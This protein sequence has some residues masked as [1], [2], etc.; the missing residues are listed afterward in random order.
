MLPALASCQEPNGSWKVLLKIAFEMKVSVNRLDLEGIFVRLMV[1]GGAGFI[2]SAVVLEGL[3][4]PG[5]SLVNVDNLTYAA[6]RTILD[7]I[8]DRPEHVFERA[9]IRDRGA[10]LAILHRHSPDVIMHLAAETHVDRSIDGPATFIDTNIVGTSVLLEAALEYW[11][12]LDSDKRKA[13]RFL[14]IS[15]DEVFGDLG[16][17]DPAFHEETRYSPSS[18]YSASKAGSDHLVRAWY[19]TYGLPVLITNCSNNYGP[20]QFPEKLIPLMIANALLGKPLPVYGNGTN[21]RDWLHVEDHAKALF[22][23]LTKGR[24]GETY[25]VGGE[26]ECSNIGLVRNICAELEIQ[27][28]TK[29]AG[30]NHYTDL[31]EFITDRP[32]HDHRYAVDISKIRS[33]LDWSPQR[34]LASGIRD[35]VA[36]YLENKDWWE[37]IL[38]NNGDYRRDDL[39]LGNAT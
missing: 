17:N 26:N 6:N 28:P 32:G 25:M 11:R 21:I 30:V 34:T 7:E 16:L 20:R 18:P 27:A 8:A 1:T 10:M 4:R 39:S 3:A 29:P 13:F 35:T 22:K 9:D 19:R 31:I 38:L 37:E 5:M 23:V 12:G 24:I 2:G 36:W 33:E 15:T 14:H